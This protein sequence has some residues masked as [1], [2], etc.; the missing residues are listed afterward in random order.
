MYRNSNFLYVYENTKKHPKIEEKI[1][2]A[3]TG[4]FAQKQKV[5]YSF[6]FLWYLGFITLSTIPIRNA[7]YIS[8]KK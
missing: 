1:Y 4:Q 6:E 2:T 8:R 7:V 5:Q 3:L